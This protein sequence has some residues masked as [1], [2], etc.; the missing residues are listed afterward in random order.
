V[1]ALIFIIFDV[2]VLFLF[3][4]AVVYKKL[5]WLAFTEMA[6]FLIIL[7]F[8]LVYVWKKRD[9]DWIK[10]NVKYGRG[11]YKKLSEKKA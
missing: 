8:G 7:I 6:I 1:I 11:R 9:L 5:G 4:W 3:P 10:Y 2:E